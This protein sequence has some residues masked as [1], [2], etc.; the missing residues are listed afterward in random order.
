MA[1]GIRFPVHDVAPRRDPDPSILQR[2]TRGRRDGPEILATSIQEGAT[3]LLE[4]SSHPLVSAV[5]LAYSRHYP[6][7]LSPDTIWITL[8][9]GLAQH[10]KLNADS[11]RRDLVRHRGKMK[12]TATMVSAETRDAEFWRD[13]VDRLTTKI[14]EHADAELVDLVCCT[15]STTG[16][17]E[18]TASQ[19]V[20]MDAVS[21][22]FKYA[23]YLICGIPSI[24]LTGTPEDWSR[25]YRKAEQLRH[26]G[27]DTWAQRILPICQQFV[28]AA[29]GEIHRSFWKR[30]LRAH[31]GCG[32][33][34]DIN[35]D[36]WICAFFPYLL[37]HATGDFSSPNLGTAVHL[38]DFP[39][40]SSTV[41]IAL[42]AMGSPVGHVEIVAG[43]HGVTQDAATGA[44]SP[45]IEWSVYEEPALTRR[46]RKGGHVLRPPRPAAEIHARVGDPGGFESLYT[47]T[48]GV[49]LHVREGRATYRI[50]PLAELESLSLTRADYIRTLEANIAH[51]R[52]TV[53]PD[54]EVSEATRQSKTIETWTRF[55]DLPDGS[56]LAQSFDSKEIAHMTDA[57]R[58][59]P[60]E[61]PRIVAPSLLEALDRALAGGPRPWFEDAPLSSP[62]DVIRTR[63]E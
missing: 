41:S 44:V 57:V 35:I 56:F 1:R 61:Q 60:I 43:L 63:P 15:F 10:I 58:A 26:Y 30:I 47:I 40:G 6:L 13:V 55:C 11:L 59:G 42:E 31:E 21:P 16:P 27:L 3:F 20:L 4:P 38:A 25:L 52:A 9:Q 12:L 2:G 32:G 17:V 34:M 53:F 29:Q 7:V 48:D 39:P 62:E 49:D 51:M 36:G 5:Y 14:R 50:L 24:T 54:Y 19:V 45:K 23:I 28:L 22:F 18:R 37:D 46:L 8:A 33:A